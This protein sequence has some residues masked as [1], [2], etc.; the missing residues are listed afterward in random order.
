M[1]ISLELQSMSL[2]INILNKISGILQYQIDPFNPV[3]V[4]LEMYLMS[5]EVV[6]HLNWVLV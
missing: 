3:L 1:I 5:C 6:K 4:H 2:M